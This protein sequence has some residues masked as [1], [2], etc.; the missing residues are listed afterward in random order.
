MIDEP[1]TK[2]S[3]QGESAHSH[4]RHKLPLAAYFGGGDPMVWLAV[5]DV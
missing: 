2:D 3:H 1:L 4:A 5:V